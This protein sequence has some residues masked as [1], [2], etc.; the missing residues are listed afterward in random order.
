MKFHELRV[1]ADENVSPKVVAF[2]RNHGPD[3]LDTKEQG[4]HGKSDDELLE[5]AYQEKR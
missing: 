1:L 2:L 3:V 4:W 5:I